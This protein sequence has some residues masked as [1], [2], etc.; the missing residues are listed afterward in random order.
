MNVE[1][2][3]EMLISLDFPVDSGWTVDQLTSVII[4][5]GMDITQFSAEEID[6]LIEMC[7]DAQQGMITME[8]DTLLQDEPVRH[9]ISF[10]GYYNADD[11]YH[12]TSYDIDGD[13]SA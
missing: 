5:N 6:Q 9:G 3:F 8:G 12:Y 2:I 11:S 13:P 4:E 1:S 10:G 7:D